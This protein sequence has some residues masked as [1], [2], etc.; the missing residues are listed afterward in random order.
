M[1]RAFYFIF[2][3]SFL[4][5]Y[6][7]CEK[8]ETGTGSLNLSITDAP[9]DNEG[10]T[11]VFITVTGIEYHSNNKGWVKFEEFE[12]PKKYNLLD[13]T[14]GTSD[15]L[16]SFKLTAGTYTQIRFILDMPVYGQGIA[17]NPGCDL[18]LEGSLTEQFFV[19]SGAQTGYKAVGTFNV[20]LNGEVDVTADFDVRKSVLKAGHSGKYILKPTIRL[21]VNNQAGSIE[22]NI[23]GVEENKSILVYAYKS[24]TYIESE[25]NEPKEENARF[26]NAVSSD[27]VDNNGF[28]HI[29]YLAN[30]RYDLV[31]TSITENNDISVITILEEIIVES[32][33]KTVINYDISE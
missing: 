18:E 30:G 11:A 17:S 7:A 3:A 14:R 6:G 29:A 19:P 32:N 4:L 5:I 1:S 8:N 27:L 9:I 15:L 26:P 12:T 23:T 31:I 28:Y 33:N 16:G 10:I 25:A 24:G 22:G 20:P 13:L 2:I 21:I